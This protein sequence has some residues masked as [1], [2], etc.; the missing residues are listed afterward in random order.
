[1]DAIET[2]AKVR[3]PRARAF[4]RFQFGKP[5]PAVLVQASQGIELWMKARAHHTAIADLGTGFVSQLLFEQRHC[6]RWSRQAFIQRPEA[7]GARIDLAK[8]LL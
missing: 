4:A 2:D 8:R 1:M 3:N 7:S 6:Q 5:A